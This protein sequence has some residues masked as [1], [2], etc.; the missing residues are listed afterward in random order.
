VTGTRRCL[1]AA[2]LAALGVA[3]AAGCSGVRV[4][5]LAD[6][7]PRQPKPDSFEVRLFVN[8]VLTSHR[9]IAIIESEALPDMSDES[10]AAQ[11]RQIQDEA[12]RL[13]ADAVHDM[14][15]LKQRVQGMVVDRNVP[16]RAYKQGRYDLYFWRGTAIVYTLF[17][18]PDGTTH[19][20][21]TK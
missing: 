17:Q 3:F 19:D 2:A 8:K 14:R 9:E 7:M 5:P 11:L 16:F 15:Q 18:T 13:G 10:K 6:D 4:I 21:E 20:E 12:R 1:L